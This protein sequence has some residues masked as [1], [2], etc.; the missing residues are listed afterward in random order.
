[1][2]VTVKRVLA[3]TA[4]V[5]VIIAFAGCAE[6]RTG[7]MYL[8]GDT[9]AAVY[10]PKLP[11][12]IKTVD[13][14]E[15]DLAGQLENRRTDLDIYF[16]GNYCAE[17]GLQRLLLS[18]AAG[19]KV[20]M[21]G[22][23]SLPSSRYFYSPPRNPFAVGVRTKTISVR[24][25]MLKF[26][27]RLFVLY[28]DLPDWPITV[29]AFGNGQRIYLGDHQVSLGLPNEE[30][31]HRIADDLY[32]IQQLMIE[33]EQAQRALFE[34]QAARYRALK[35]K[36]QISEEQRKLIVQANYFTQQKEYG[37]A[38]DCYNQTIAVDPVAYP[39]AYFNMALLSAQEHRF[40]SA[41]RYMKQYLLLVPD[42]KDARSAHDKIYEWEIKAPQESGNKKP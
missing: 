42:A 4:C 37:K 12:G 32:F 27:L 17:H 3:F 14:A 6:T 9:S 29:Q 35:V 24:D 30:E 28:A 11:V 16:Y 13:A 5:F 18:G 38:I 31:A 36:P 22:S 39:A 21:E 1:M 40:R 23:V 25:D 20:I 34:S 2:K 7:D 8:T 41:I 19:W 26:S 15:K 10:H 33:N